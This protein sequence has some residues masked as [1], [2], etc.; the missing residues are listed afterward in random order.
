[1]L[2]VILVYL[3][4]MATDVRVATG[5]ASVYWPGD[6]HSGRRR[7]D[8]RVFRRADRHVAHRR[9]PLGTR[10]VLCLARTGRCVM[11]RIH[12]RGPFG[13]VGSCPDDGTTPRGA[14]R[15]RARRGGCQLWQAQRRLQAGWRYRGEFDVT[16][17]V[18]EELRLHHGERVLFFHVRDEPKGGFP[19][20]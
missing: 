17:P 19:S 3:L 10:G 7:A 1:M 5:V 16:R 4:S 2:S 14:R 8:G 11:T 15:I 18:A 6:G 9:L 12:D 13:A 20:T